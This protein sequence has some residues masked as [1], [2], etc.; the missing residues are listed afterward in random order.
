MLANCSLAILLPTLLATGTDFPVWLGVPT[1]IFL[2][3]GFTIWILPKA[4]AMGNSKIG[5]AMLVCLQALMI[6]I[7][8]AMARKIIADAVQLPPES[9]D[10]TVAL[11]SVLL[12]PVAW[13]V[14]I[15]TLIVAISLALT[16][17]AAII[18]S[19]IFLLQTLS[20]VLPF[21]AANNRFHGWCATLY[22]YQN[23]TVERMTGAFVVA[24]VI[25]GLMAGYGA[26]VLDRPT[27]RFLA[28]LLDFNIAEDYPG[29]RHGEP[30]RLLENGLVVYAKRDGFNVKFN[31]DHVGG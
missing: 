6:P 17:V 19:A 10:A 12:I 25:C 2:F 9:F 30:M 28:Y 16:V 23:R 31:V 29:V 15:I 3:M 21:V 22:S 8:L 5:V 18:V 4:I 7:C 11:I 20:T 26:L 13:A 27:V 1:L 24:L 14:F